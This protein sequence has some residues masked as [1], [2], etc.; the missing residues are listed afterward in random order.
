MHCENCGKELPAGMRFCPSCGTRISQDSP[1]PPP[2]PP[3]AGESAP[4]RQ[5]GSTAGTPPAQSLPMQ[6]P[7]AQG[8]GAPPPRHDDLSAPLRTGQ[9]IG[10]LLLLAI[11]IV[12]IVMLFVWAFSSD[13]NLNRR[14][15]A[16]AILILMA[17]SLGIMFVVLIV[18]VAL[19]ASMGGMIA[20][21][22]ASLFQLY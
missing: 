3:P 11:P 7:P 6:P 22:F 14:N 2:P 19:V 4:P 10:M 15:Y 13:V 20:D 9:Y 17:I 18:S 8:Y 5:Y 21:W 12:N 16:R 1:A